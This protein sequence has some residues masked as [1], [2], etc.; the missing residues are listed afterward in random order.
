[1]NDIKKE[2]LEQFEDET[3][4]FIH[5]QDD[6]LIG[7]A[8]MFGNPCILIYKDINFIPL[9]PDDAIEKIQKINPEARTHDGTDNSAIGHLTLEDGSTVLLYDRESLVEEL[10]KG[11]MEDETGL[12]EDEDD[13]ETSAWDW[14]YVNSLGSYMSGIPAFAVL[15]SK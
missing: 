6:K 15:Y 3:I 7:Y 14:Y 5:G 1:M 8:E 2:I 12:F 13:C 11:Y 4:E 9:S 10:K